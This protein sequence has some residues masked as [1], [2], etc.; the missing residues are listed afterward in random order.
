MGQSS[1]SLAQHTA[2]VKIALLAG[3]AVD[4]GYSRNW[5]YSTLA[6]F[7]GACPVVTKVE[8]GHTARKISFVIGGRVALDLQAATPGLC[9]LDDL[10]VA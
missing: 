6:A 2:G 3:A 5:F 1:A 10:V 9:Y 4:P 7:G 8:F